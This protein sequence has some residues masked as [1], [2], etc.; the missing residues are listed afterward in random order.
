MTEEKSMFKKI[1]SNPRIIILF[2]SLIIALLFMNP[3]LTEGV[4]I[5]G[6]D[7][8]SPA[9][10]ALPTPITSPDMDIKPRNREVIKSI[11]DVEVRNLE[12]YARILEGINP[13][14]LVSIETNKENYFLEASSL[15][16]NV[17]G[18]EI[19]YL[20]LNVMAK[21]TT[22]IRTGLDISGGTRVLLEP[23]GE[24]TGE[25]V[26]LI[27]GSIEQRLDV[28]GLGDVTVTSAN[29]LFGNVFILVEIGGV[30]EA[31]V[32]ELLSRQG[33]FEA[34]I[35]NETIFRGG[36]QD[37][38]FVC[39][40]ADCAGIKPGTCREISANEHSCE[41][42]FSI[43]LSREA[44]QRQA[45]LTR[46]LDIIGG[47]NGYL[48]ENLSLFLDGSLVNELRISASLRGNPVTDIEI[49]GGGSGPTRQAAVDDAMA[50]MRQIQTVI[51]TGSLPVE[52]N[53]VKVDNISPVVGSGFVKNALLAGL[54][55]IIAVV[56]IVSI[57]Y[58]E[59]KISIPMSLTMLAEV[60]LLLGLASAINWSIDMAA[61][62]AII[63]A[64]GSGVDHQIV[65]AEET[66]ARNKNRKYTLSWKKRLAK[67]FFI[68][69]AAY[70]T[71]VVAMVP[72]YFAGAGLLKGF[73]VTTIMG[74][75]IG[76]IITRPAFAAILQIILNEK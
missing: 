1:V 31:E 32:T 3:T 2:L 22:N 56:T 52:L 48:S 76:V 38:I 11:N 62:A 24:V 58:R 13:G 14:D 15:Y 21:P 35:G 12:D 67:A 42:G 30:N 53:I 66:L 8:D 46:D 7:D 40:T 25:D 34:K 75:T 61:I 19:T 64:V 71:L 74:V 47:P 5:R 45:D 37:I 26:N 9:M 10:N 73:A 65:I 70:F 60:I 63:I 4:A 33:V 23:D 51:I 57:R 18:E 68:I 16:D 49:S 72:L 36:D 41:Y 20:G 27:I 17:T 29:D 55:A 59:I 39:R 28:F 6:V 44:A 54:F 50:S 43:S 69:M